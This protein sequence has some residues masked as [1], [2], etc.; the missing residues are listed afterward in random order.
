MCHDDPD[1]QKQHFQWHILPLVSVLHIWFSA[2]QQW[3][4]EVTLLTFS[5]QNLLESQNELTGY[6][7]VSV[8]VLGRHN[9]M[10]V[11]TSVRRRG[12]MV[13][14]F[15]CI[16]VFEGKF[17][18][19]CEGADHRSVCMLCVGGLEL[20]VCV[21]VCACMCVCVCVR[22]Q[23]TRLLGVEA[24]TPEDNTG[25]VMTQSAQSTC[26]LS[27]TLTH[28]RSKAASFCH[29]VFHLSTQLTCSI[30]ICYVQE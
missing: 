9:G 4:C 28:T 12:L 2:G 17:M 15:V 25:W 16:C 13:W 24:Q 10:C 21:H 18:A 8:C 7:G 26:S 30:Q 22:S 29:S 20:S 19:Q 11:R 5:T 6:A 23:V 1:W 27:L 3:V 14:W